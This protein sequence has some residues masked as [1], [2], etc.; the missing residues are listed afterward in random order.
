[1]DQHGPLQGRQRYSFFNQKI[2]EEEAGGS[3]EKR[4]REDG[5]G[6]KGKRD[7]EYEGGSRDN[8]D[9]EDGGRSRGHRALPLLMAYLIKLMN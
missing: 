9:R 3:K 1:M 4:D 7:K 8:R 6:S 2:E 5:E